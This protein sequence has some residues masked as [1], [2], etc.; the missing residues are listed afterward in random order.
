M[1]IVIISD[2]HGLNDYVSVPECDTII[3]C[4]DFTRTGNHRDVTLFA[5]WFSKL[6]FKNRICIAGIHDLSLESTHPD[7][8]K[9]I[10]T[11]FESGITYLQ[12]S[13]ISFD[14]VKFYGS[15]WQPEFCNWGFN[16]PRGYALKQKWNQIPDDTNVLITHGPPHGTLD[17]VV[18]NKFNQGRDLH[19]GCE[20]LTIRV[21]QLPN[22]KLHCFG[23]LHL[24]GG[25]VEYFNGK[26]FVNA[27]ICNEAYEPV[28]KP[29]VV[30]I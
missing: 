29:I 16:L 2:T 9:V 28:N 23:H 30:E 20:E 21:N 7:R 19:Q 10:K 11:L 18:N 26:F 12:D 5:N 24:N 15:P 22:I 6:D 3:H 17:L 4:G 1:K 14:N 27:A 25:Q 13:A 8:K